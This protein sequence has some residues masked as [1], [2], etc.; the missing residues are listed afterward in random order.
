MNSRAQ[1]LAAINGSE[2]FPIP[3]DIIENGFCPK[4]RTELLQHFDLE[5]DDY[6]GLRLF[7]VRDLKQARCE[8]LGTCLAY[9]LAE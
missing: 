7:H 8:A 5:A 1:V 6:D 3:A 4:L 9:S 2:V